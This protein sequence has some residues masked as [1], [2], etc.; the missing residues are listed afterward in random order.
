MVYGERDAVSAD[1]PLSQ[2][3]N[4]GFAVAWLHLFFFFS[5]NEAPRIM[6]H[7]DVSQIKTRVSV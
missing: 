3:G 1:W 2:S 6:L 5:F 4:R 7:V